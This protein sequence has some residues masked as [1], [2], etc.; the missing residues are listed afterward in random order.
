[1]YIYIYIWN[2]NLGAAR[3]GSLGNCGGI[4]LGG[5]ERLLVLQFRCSSQRLGAHFGLC[6]YCR[7]RRAKSQGY[8]NGWVDKVIQW[9]KYIQFDDVYEN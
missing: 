5:S 6:L 9:Q 1:M 7:E 8:A 3:T 4:N 2:S